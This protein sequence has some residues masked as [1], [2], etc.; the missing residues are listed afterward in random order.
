MAPAWRPRLSDLALRLRGLRGGRALAQS[1]RYAPLAALLALVA[2]NLAIT[3]HF[4]SWQTLSLNL[5]QVTTT[6]IV[7]VG[8]T[9]VIATGGIDLSAGSLMAISGALA[10]M[11]LLGRLGPVPP[12]LAVP[13]AF[14][15]PVALT[16]ALGWCNG[17]LVTRYRVQPI[18]ATL[19]LF[20]A[21]RGVAQVATNGKLQ[22]FHAPAFQVIGL[23]QVAGVP[24]QVLV[25]LAI[26]VAAA[27]AMRRTVFGRQ[28]LAVGGNP[29]AAYLAGI[30]AARLTRWVYVISGLCAGVAGLIVIAI[31]SSADANAVGLG[32]ELDA[33]AAVAVGGTLLSGGRA[34]IGGTVIGALIIQIMRYMLLSNGVPDAVAMVVKAGLIILAVALQRQGRAQ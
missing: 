17:L 20:T 26:A 18:V 29:R 15:L 11:V 27:W 25:M 1:T 5:T 22:T 4:L 32:V 21:G 10:P 33:I 7:G 19:I 24:V 34:S 3:P 30:A 6:I 16:G 28:V 14:I 9:L 8:M 13:L 31:N 2:A 23:G 12:A